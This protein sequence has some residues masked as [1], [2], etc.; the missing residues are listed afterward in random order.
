MNE[1]K[2][3]IEKRSELTVLEKEHM[4]RYTYLLFYKFIVSAAFNGIWELKKRNF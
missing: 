4:S 3:L 2:K 1:M